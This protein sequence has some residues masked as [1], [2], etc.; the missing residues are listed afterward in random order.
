MTSWGCSK[1]TRCTIELSSRRDL[2]RSGEEGRRG[3]NRA[4]VGQAWAVDRTSAARR[5]ARSTRRSSSLRARK[6][7]ARRRRR[8]PR[9]LLPWRNKNFSTF[10]SVV[11]ATAR[12]A[13]DYFG[14]PARSRRRRPG[15]GTYD[16]A[17]EGR[18][19]TRLASRA[20]NC[21][22][23]SE[24]RARSRQLAAVRH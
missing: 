13:S 14:D 2:L 17:G 3:T 12:V 24:P 5:T 11:A 1:L 9:F 15:E 6:V 23:A 22:V 21:Y 7:A 19:A 8:R 20:G 18:W 10:F 4:T 16:P